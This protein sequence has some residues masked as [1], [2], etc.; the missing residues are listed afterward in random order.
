MMAPCTLT[1]I[2][3]VYNTARFLPACLESLLGETRE[4]TEILL[5]DDGSSDASPAM[6]AAFCQE[7]P[8]FR[9]IRQANQGL[10]GARNTGLEQARGQYVAFCDSDDFVT[11]GYYTRLT[12]QAQRQAA[13]LVVG[14][15]TYHFE[16]READYPLYREGLPDA[17]MT[18]RAWLK[19][20]LTQQSLLHMV[21]MQV[22]RRDLI[23]RLG[24]RFTLGIW[25]E[26][27]TWTTRMLLH[28]ERIAFWNEP[29]YFYRQWKRQ[30]VRSD[31]FLRVSALSYVTNT[32]ILDAMARDID[33]PELAA[34]LRWQL[35]DD[36]LSMFHKIDR[37]AA[38]QARK[39][40]RNEV[41]QRGAYGILWRNAAL[42]R[43][44][45][46]IA[47]Q[48]LKRISPIQ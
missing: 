44:K 42:L 14:N 18:G 16:G 2:V 26:D 38:A 5:I 46:R 3:P 35:V 6:L 39:N 12:A 11:P 17:N 22:Y 13:E 29:G 23:D 36:G 10:S 45:R 43:H 9:M 34:L 15:A 47:K 27:V 32:Q 31:A 19:Q 48:W 33:D 41:W 25:H 21:C 30:V 28:A 7:H 4:T 1:V 24:L 8:W 40:C 20:R 37:M